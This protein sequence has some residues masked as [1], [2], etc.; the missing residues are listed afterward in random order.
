L[1]SILE[2]SKNLDNV[3]DEQLH[4]IHSFS[5]GPPKAKVVQRTKMLPVMTEMVQIKLGTPKGKHSIILLD[6]GASTA[7]M[8]EDIAAKLRVK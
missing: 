1:Q 5:R 7:I 2:Y 3:S 6:S 4:S 8:R